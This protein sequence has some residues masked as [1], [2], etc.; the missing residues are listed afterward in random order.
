M[1]K[2]SIKREIGDVLRWSP[3]C[4][5]H[6]FPWRSLAKDVRDARSIAEAGITECH[7]GYLLERFEPRYHLLVYPMNG[8]G[9][10]Y[11]TAHTTTVQP[12]ELLIAPAQK[13]FGYRPKSATW[14]FMWW[15]LLTDESWGGLAKRELTVR[16]TVLSEPLR[17]A[18][19]ELLRESRGRSDS[20][21]EISAAYVRLIALY[22]R[23]EL[24]ASIGFAQTET[25]DRLEYLHSLISSDLAR[26]WTVEEMAKAIDVSSSYLHRLVRQQFRMSPMKLVTS[27]RMERAQEWLITHD[28]PQRVVAELVGYQDEFAFLV[29][30]KRY[31]SVTPKQFRKRG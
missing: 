2:Q 8:T 29:A 11:D 10:V 14:R 23:R 31:W 13:P 7:R 15:H 18:T 17:K 16:K 28:A 1:P 26:R 24:A 30:F 25:G 20:H 12:G 21:R 19:E 9:E 5:E 3:K 4:K 6:F 27:L 22:I